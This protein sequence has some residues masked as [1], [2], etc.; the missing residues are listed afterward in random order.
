MSMLTLVRHGQASFFADDY[1]V[2]SELGSTQGRL[3]G[4]YWAA[5]RVR[6]DAV[7]TGPRVRQ[8]H[9][10]EQVCSAYREAGLALPEPVVLDELDE[11][12]L[13]GLRRGLAPILAQ[14]DT[15]FAALFE[16]Y[17]ASQE[18]GE[19]AR[20][21]QKMF[22]VLVD[23]WQEDSPLLREIDLKMESWQSFRAGGAGHASNVGDAWSRGSDRRVHLGRVHR[24]CRA[25]DAR[26]SGPGRHGA[27]L[28]ASQ[29]CPLRIHLQPRAAFA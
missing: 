2:L 18:D 23:H 27:E 3:L 25:D 12:D 16:R 29:R 20:H 10:A 7:Y 4:E 14:R 28:A 26:G 13:E 1:D 19:R 24:H 5:R 8:R 17:R 22:E 11:Y 9:T 15:G 21:F 6:L